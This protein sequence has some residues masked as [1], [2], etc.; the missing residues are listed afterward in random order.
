MTATGE[1]IPG[2]IKVTVLVESMTAT[3]ESLPGGIKVTV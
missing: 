1:L 2:G 3:G